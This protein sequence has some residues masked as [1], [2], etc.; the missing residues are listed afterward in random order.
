[1]RG[2]SARRN[3]LIEVR[4]IVRKDVCFNHDPKTITSLVS[5]SVAEI[6]TETSTNMT[7]DL[8]EYQLEE[9]LQEKIAKTF[10]NELVLGAEYTNEGVLVIV[11]SNYPVRQPTIH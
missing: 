7:L 10:N 11:S 2:N 5:K 9:M 3:I 8:P 1:M 4:V 6:A